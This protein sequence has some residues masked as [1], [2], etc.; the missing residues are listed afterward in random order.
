MPAPGDEDGARLLAGP[1]LP[2]AVVWLGKI[3]S[4]RATTISFGAIVVIAVADLMTALDLTFTLLYVFPIAFG[5]WVGGRRAGIACAVLSGT[6]VAVD[7]AVSTGDARLWARAW[8]D[9]GALGIFLLTV[10]AIDLVRAHFEREKRGR[11]VAITQLRHAERLNLIGKLAAGV[12]HELG[13]P[14]NVI[15][16]SVEMLREQRDPTETEELTS[17]I[18]S[19]TDR[20]TGILQHLLDFGRRGGLT[21]EREELNAIVERT[22]VLLFSLLRKTDCVLET[23][24]TSEPSHAVV[25]AREIEQVLSNLIVNAAQAMQPKGGIVR[26]TTERI[27]GPPRTPGRLRITV[28]DTGAGIAAADLPRV[29]DPFFTTKGVGEGTGLGLSVSYGIIS[30]HGGAIEVTSAQGDGTTFSI[31]LDLVE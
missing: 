29:F 2:A 18:L 21:R 5:T 20:M 30:D 10:W 25:C 27:D 23:V 28:E 22:G 19:Q 1:P 11:T 9:V 14:L 13:T 15:T 4:G 26:V 17:A 16:G 8:N 6:C 3:S 31:V 24:L 7:S 12:A